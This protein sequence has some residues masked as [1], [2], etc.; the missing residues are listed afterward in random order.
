LESGSKDEQMT[1]EHFKILAHFVNAHREDAH[2]QEL[3]PSEF[4]TVRV[5]VIVLDKALGLYVD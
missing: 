4:A 1:R 5:A 3:S 2:A